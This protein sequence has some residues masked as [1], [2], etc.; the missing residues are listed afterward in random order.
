M[1]LETVRAA[2]V[3]DIRSTPSRP[4]SRGP[5]TREVAKRFRIS[6][7]DAMRVLAGLA[8]DG[9]LMA[10]PARYLIGSRPEVTA[11]WEKHVAELIQPHLDALRADG[12]NAGDVLDALRRAE[13]RSGELQGPALKSIVRRLIQTR[14]EARLS[15]GEVARKIGVDFQRVSLL[16]RSAVGHRAIDQDNLERYARALGYRITIDL[17]P[18]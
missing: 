16:E 2:L 13:Q 17:K 18:E 11:A 15:Q 9:W 8:S 12:L 14:L 3:A 4:G 6:I 7:S 5:T 10:M 1:D